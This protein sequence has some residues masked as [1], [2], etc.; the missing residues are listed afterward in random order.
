MVEEEYNESSKRNKGM[1]MEGNWPDKK[2]FILDIEWLET[3]FNERGEG[4]YNPILQK[5]SG[6]AD[7]SCYTLSVTIVSN[8]KERLIVFHPHETSMEYLQDDANTSCFSSL[9]SFLFASG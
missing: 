4:F 5:K 6:Q 9:T 8:K 2:W 3:Y 7:S 1:N